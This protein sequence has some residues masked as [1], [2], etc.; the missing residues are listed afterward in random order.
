MTQLPFFDTV[1]IGATV[2]AAGAVIKD[3]SA[4]K[5]ACIHDA[6]AITAS[7]FSATFYAGATPLQPPETA[8]DTKRGDKKTHPPQA[9]PSPVRGMASVAVTSAELHD[10]VETAE[11]KAFRAELEKRAVLSE[12]TVVP[13][14]LTP[15]VS[16][17]LYDRGISCLF[18]TRVLD[19]ARDGDSHITLTY[20][21]LGKAYKLR[22]GRIVD[23]TP[24]FA[25]RAFA[26]STPPE[27]KRFLSSPLTAPSGQNSD[28]DTVNDALANC[29]LDNDKGGRAFVYR[30]GRKTLCLAYPVNTTDIGAA[31]ASLF[32]FWKERPTALQNCKLAAIA[33]AVTCI[34]M[35]DGCSTDLFTWLPS[36][37]SMPDLA[38]DL[39]VRFAC[40]TYPYKIPDTVPAKALTVQNAGRYDIAVVGLGTAGAVSAL[41]AKGYGRQADF[42]AQTVLGIELTG[43]AGGTGAAAGGVDGYFY[44]FKGGIYREIDK[45]AGDIALAD[46]NHMPLAKSLAL[47]TE[48]ARYGVDCHYHESF[49]RITADG[50]TVTGIQWLDGDGLHRAETRFVIDCT[51][52]SAVCDAAGC[53]MTA[54]RGSDHVF[55]PYSNVARCLYTD[56]GT[57]YHSNLDEGV[58]DQYDPHAFGRAVLLSSSSPLH[59]WERYDGDTL[60]LG[61]TALP[62]MREGKKIIG[63]ESVTFSDLLTGD[64]TKQPIYFGLSNLDHHAKDSAFESRLYRDWITVCSMWGYNVGIPVPRGALI[65]RGKDGLLVAGRNVSTDHDIAT[66]LRMKDDAQ[67]AGEAAAVLATLA[68]QNRTTAKAVPYDALRKALL[69]TGCLSPDDSTKVMRQ[70]NGGGTH[71]TDVHPTVLCDDI[72]KILTELDA[73]TP[74]YAIFAAGAY[75]GSDAAAL[76]EALVDGMRGNTTAS[77]PHY[78]EHCTLALAMRGDMRCE[79]PL[80]ACIEDKS[81]A[82]PQNSW[83]HNQLYA[84]SAISASG[85]MGLSSAIKP[86][87]AII[88]NKHYADDIPLSGEPYYGYQ[89][90]TDKEDLYF[91]LFTHA[92]MSLYEITRAHPE[93]RESVGAAVRRVTDAPDFH[94]DVSHVTRRDLR[95]C[96]TELI[97]QIADSI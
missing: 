42:P 10:T 67:K 95:L 28:I 27:M 16:R 68:I 17:M 35:T 49:A 48:L 80:L 79:T 5:T 63:E 64:E 52:E 4:G 36:K 60:Y 51:A 37:A 2:F 33:D 1:Y 59:L 89:F 58:V 86:L 65:P 97:R 56:G 54:G 73:D 74:G 38:F 40:G 71:P 8:D 83:T 23:T 69:A 57:T 19:M 90:I 70:S 39:G 26:D 9:V 88:E 43:C 92:L 31:R 61:P 30:I 77:H 81:G 96:D 76:T 87:L 15:I 29:P 3:A 41:A 66:A 94:M 55:Q 12:N 47:E 62:G 13:T 46:T 20:V 53:E 24:H 82:A 45:T 25:L 72:Q 6:G 21:Y 18:M 11:G 84:V 32:R 34:P 50:D 85:K 22:C 93:Y 75:R 91:H 14:A 78:A 7:E 44:G